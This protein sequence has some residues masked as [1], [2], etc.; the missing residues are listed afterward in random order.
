MKKGIRQNLL[1]C[2]FTLAIVFIVV[3]ATYATFRYSS[4]GSKIN[5]IST[6]S[7]TM[8][9]KEGNTKISI[10]DAMPI[11]D[12][13]GKTLSLENQ[14]F[15]FGIDALV[16]S[17]SK[18]VY[19][20]VAV[21][22]ES[23]TLDNNSVKLYLERSTDGTNFEPVL[24]P[25]YYTPLA[26]TDSLGAPGGDMVLDTGTLIKSAN[27]SYRLRMWIPKEY[28][29]TGESKTFTVRVNVYSK[30]ATSN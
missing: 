12:S 13:V 9:Y 16:S 8:V 10:D 28:K 6:A 7:V 27:Y 21:K 11:E 25:S 1:I 18:I 29:M 14:V 3:G 22:D 4:K 19:E 23:S 17:G 30:D 20:V 15:N 24:E 5:E 26:E 2:V